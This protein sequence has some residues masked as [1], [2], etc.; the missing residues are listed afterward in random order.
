M[1]L[2]QASDPSATRWRTPAL[3]YDCA[4]PA[5]GAR[6]VLRLERLELLGCDRSRIEQRLGVGELLGR[7]V[8]ATS[9]CLT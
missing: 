5:F 1:A 7:G 2:R 9:R 8:P 6:S 4:L 3:G